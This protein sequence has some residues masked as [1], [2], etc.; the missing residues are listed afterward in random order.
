MPLFVTASDD[1]KL[2]RSDAAYV[3]VIHTNAMVQGKLEQ[4]GHS[5]FYMN[6]GINQ[7]GCG[8]WSKIISIFFFN[9]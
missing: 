2:D 3:D 1:D 4:C 5:D 7:P 9:F 6:G 8:G